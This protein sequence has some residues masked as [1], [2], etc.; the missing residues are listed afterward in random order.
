MVR[1]RRIHRLVSFRFQKDHFEDR[2]LQTSVTLISLSV[3][4]NVEFLVILGRNREASN[5][6]YCITAN[7]DREQSADAACELS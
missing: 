7:P 5:I 6:Q 1:F 2:T 3:I 4:E